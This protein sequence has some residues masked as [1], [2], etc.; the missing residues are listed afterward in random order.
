MAGPSSVTPRPVSPS[1]S[2]KRFT[3][4]EAN[5]SLPLVKRIVAD[6][7]KMHDQ[8]TALQ[9]SLA[10]AKG[11]D[12]AS[13]QSKLDRAAEQLQSYVDELMAIGCQL[14]DFQLGLVDFIGRHQSRDVCLCW[15]M[16]EDSIGFWHELNTGIT[17]RQPVSTLRE[18]A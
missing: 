13:A 4:A 18:P 5:R 2:T 11:A 17:G 15:K 16:G 6:V 8:V 9:V 1:N 12:L 7:M 10:S 3:L 14:K